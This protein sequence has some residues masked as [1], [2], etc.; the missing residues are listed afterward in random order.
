MLTYEEF[1]ARLETMIKVYLGEDGTVEYITNTKNNGT[2]KE[3]FV[4][5][6]VD[7]KITPCVYTKAMYED[8]IEGISLEEI[9]EVIKM[10]FEERGLVYDELLFSDWNNAKRF[11]TV[12]VVNTE[13]NKEA[14]EQMSHRNCLNLSV[15]CKCIVLEDE[16]RRASFNVTYDRMKDWGITEEELWDVAFSNLEKEQFHMKDLYAMMSMI[17]EEDRTDTN[18]LY[19]LTNENNKDGAKAI[20][21]PEYFKDLADKLKSDLFIIPS[22]IHELLCLSVDEGHTVDEINSMIH[23]INH[24]QLDEEDRLGDNAYLYSRETGEVTIAE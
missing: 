14:L 21:R 4:L 7:Q 1:K 6:G 20:L 23:D 5:K 17:D 24:T 19:V 11:I 16:Q 3:A 10:V 12:A 2:Q 15:I 9:M 22:S 8:Y 13:W 18:Y